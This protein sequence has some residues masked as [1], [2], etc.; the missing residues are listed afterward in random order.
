MR[1][2][3]L[4]RQETDHADFAG[5][6]TGQY[7]MNVQQ[8]K[9]SA[10]YAEEK[11]VTQRYVDKIPQQPSSEKTNRRRNRRPKRNIK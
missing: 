5:H 10:T 2:Q 7:Y 11:D 3:K 8:S 4:D 1:D 9:E 6:R